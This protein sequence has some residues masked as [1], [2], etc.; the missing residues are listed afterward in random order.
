MPVDAIQLPRSRRRDR[1][2][3]RVRRGRSRGEALDLRERVPSSIGDLERDTARR[4]TGPKPDAQDLGPH[5]NH[6]HAGPRD[7]QHHRIAADIGREQVQ[8]GVEQRRVNHE[9]IELR[10][11]VEPHLGEASVTHPPRPCQAAERGPRTRA[12]ARPE[13]A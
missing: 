6:L 10:V 7:R 9:T 1:S 12:R 11:A 13:S 2:T 8:R 3:Q 5:R 4:R